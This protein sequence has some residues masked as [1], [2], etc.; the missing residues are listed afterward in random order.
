M[1]AGRT[2]RPAL[3][4]LGLEAVS[5]D[6]RLVVGIA[7]SRLGRAVRVLVDECLV[8][9]GLDVLLVLSALMPF[10]LVRHHA[11]FRR[12][13]RV[14]SDKTGLLATIF[15]LLGPKGNTPLPA[16]A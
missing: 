3:A 12:R 11:S 2:G 1:R 15:P 7:R 8:A 14:P 4:R 6:V 9:M 13:V 5:F 10:S 16:S